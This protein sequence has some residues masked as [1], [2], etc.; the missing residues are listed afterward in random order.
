MFFFAINLKP[1]EQFLKHCRR[2]YLIYNSYRLFESDLGVWIIPSAQ[3]T[4]S[5]V[6]A[7]LPQQPISL[8]AFNQHCSM[9]RH[10][11]RTLMAIC[12]SISWHMQWLQPVTTYHLWAARYIHAIQDVMLKRLVAVQSCQ[13]SASVTRR[14]TVHCQQHSASCRTY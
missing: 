10:L 13:S 14:C 3:H 11:V 12:D 5:S 7:L 9:S 6:L 8:G 1:L 2:H 4:Q